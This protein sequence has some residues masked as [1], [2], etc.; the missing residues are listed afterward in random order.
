MLWMSWN[1]R[2]RALSINYII[3]N[4]IT[5]IISQ[6]Y[7]N[8]QKEEINSMEKLL[9][10][11]KFHSCQS[12]AEILNV[13]KDNDRNMNLKN[14]LDLLSLLTYITVKDKSKKDDSYHQGLRILS[15]NLLR[16]IRN[17]TLNQV[18]YSFKLLSIC[19]IPLTTFVM[20]NLLQVIRSNVNHLNIHQV[21]LI[22]IILKKIEPT[23]LS[24]A[25]QI[26][27]PILVPTIINNNFDYENLHDL[28]LA[29][30]YFKCEETSRELFYKLCE[31]IHLAIKKNYINASLVDVS[32]IFI[33]LCKVPQIFHKSH[34]YLSTISLAQKMLLTRLKELDKEMIKTLLYVISFNT[35][36]GFMVSY[37]P[38][39]I[40]LSLENLMKKQINWYDGCIVLDYLNAMKYVYK[41]FLE[42][43]IRQNT[44]DLLSQTKNYMALLHA[45]SNA[46]YT[47]VPWLSTEDRF[48]DPLIMNALTSNNLINY[49]LLLLSLNL[50]YPEPL[51][52]QVFLKPDKFLYTFWNRE[53]L[54]LLHQL[55]KAFYPKYEG[56]WLPECILKKLY[57]EFTLQFVTN[58]FKS[59]LEEAMG[60]PQ[61]VLS[62][63]KTKI[64][65]FIDYVIMMRKDGHAVAFNNAQSNILRNFNNYIED[66]QCP[67][68]NYIILICEFFHQ[69]YIINTQ[70]LRKKPTLY[71]KSLE[72]WTNHKCIEINIDAWKALLSSKKV[73]YFMEKINKVNNDVITE[74]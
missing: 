46:G 31:S 39:F 2:S 51:I 25:L 3:G 44:G 28:S 64:G 14:I 60:G 10:S 65:H 4:K 73:L 68:G 9:K 32:R 5:K 53:K 56:P 11:N 36:K 1:L 27:L 70:Q 69:D 55:V 74:T 19:G 52:S 15:N 41:P 67:P 35:R 23:P 45:S 13:M 16:Q 43:I 59:Q 61:Y 33:S 57:D 58:A 8:T 63:V 71:L 40:N 24:S 22:M 20:Q 66:L 42:Y 29:L 72:K 17:M 21:H 7:G 54:L 38:T 34:I 30:H 49:I 37:N 48:C 6:N 62:S 18:I 12:C 47:C 50:Y 26:A